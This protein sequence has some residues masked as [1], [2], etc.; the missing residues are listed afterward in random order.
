MRKSFYMTAEQI[1]TNLKQLANAQ[2]AA[3]MAKFGSTPARAL[4]ISIPTLRKMAKEIGRNHLL[5]AELWTSGIHEARILA[6][7]IDEPQLVTAQQMDDWVH[8]FDSWD[9]CDQVCGNLFDKTPYA[10]QKAIQWCAQEREFVRRAGFV[11]MAELAV[12][13]KKASD[14]AFLPFFPLIQHYA[15]DP[16]NFV[17]KAVNW[18]LRQIGK[19]N[20]HLRTLALA[21]ADDILRM[22][23][24][25]AR[26]VAKDAIRE[27]LQLRSNS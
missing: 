7:M 19:R 3:G 4:G 18:A 8:D 23:A 27:L 16:R 24:K 17:K 25:S 1:I 13:D 5:A 15:D 10:Y 14:E 26:W 6:S 21:C 12:H 2:A 20:S 22:D 11:M 9:V